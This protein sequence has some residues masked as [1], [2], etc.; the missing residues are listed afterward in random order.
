MSREGR[1][2]QARDCVFR[3]IPVLFFLSGREPKNWGCSSCW[4]TLP[5]SVRRTSIGSDRRW[6]VP[7]VAAWRSSDDEMPLHC[8]AA[9]SAL[10]HLKYCA[11]IHV[12]PHIEADQ[13]FRS[14][15]IQKSAERGGHSICHIR[16]RSCE[17]VRP[18]RPERCS[19]LGRDMGLACLVLGYE[20]ITLWAG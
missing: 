13:K 16:Y 6:A 3:V 4:T 17:C 2:F 20:R 14:G 12:Q 11:T 19:L 15:K 18:P 9:L 8:H 1:G 5:R 7:S 10:T